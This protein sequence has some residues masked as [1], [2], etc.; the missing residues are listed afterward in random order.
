MSWVDAEGRMVGEPVY[1]L[2]QHLFGPAIPAY[3]VSTPRKPGH[4]ELVFLDQR[5]RRLAAKPYLVTNSMRTSRETFGKR[6]PELGLNMV[7]IEADPT[8]RESLRI[9]L[10]NRSDLYFQTLNAHGPMVRS[11]RAHPGLAT[12]G[13]GSLSIWVHVPSV[14]GRR[15]QNINFNLPHDLAPHGRIELTLPSDR[16]AGAGE[17][18]KAEITPNFDHVGRHVASPEAADVRMTITREQTASLASPETSR[19]RY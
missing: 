2:F 4:Y 6:V 11:V 13:P 9:V 5:R 14:E 1:A 10:E 19:A 7:S 17:R 8:A 12:P 15:E 18:I 16:L 3:T